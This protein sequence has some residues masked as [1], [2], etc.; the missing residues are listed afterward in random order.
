MVVNSTFPL[1]VSTNAEYAGNS[2][3]LFSKSVT[4]CCAT[5]KYPISQ[6]AKVNSLLMVQFYY[7]YVARTSPGEPPVR[8]TMS[9]LLRTGRFAPQRL[10]FHYLPYIHLISIK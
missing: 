5:A 4:C 3:T 8:R 1:I 6:Q 9:T 10:F 7:I 2:D